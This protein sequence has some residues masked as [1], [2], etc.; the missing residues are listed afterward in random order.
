M[1]AAGRDPPRLGQARRAAKGATGAFRFAEAVS[2]AQVDLRA[3][4]RPQMG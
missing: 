2:D 1:E 4:A 3:P